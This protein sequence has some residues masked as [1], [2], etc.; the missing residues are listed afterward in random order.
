[1]ASK[2]RKFSREYK[3]TVVQAFQTGVPIGEVIR[4]F[5]VHPNMVYKWTQEYRQ[6]PTGAFRDGRT[7]ATSNGTTE[8]RIAELERMVG[9]LAMENDFL[10]K[11]LKQLEHIQRTP[12][13]T[14]PGG[15]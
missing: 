1:M 3:L 2:R 11:A 8:T 13:T 7:V 14:T 9:R 10:K 15:D 5:D 6:N 4:Q 12:S